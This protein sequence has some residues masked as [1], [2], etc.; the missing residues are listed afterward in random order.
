MPE[1]QTDRLS[2]LWNVHSYTH[3]YI[4][5]ADAKACV[6][7]AWAGALLGFLIS[8]DAHK[9]LLT[10]PCNWQVF[11]LR[12]AAVLAFACLAAS[13]VLAVIVVLPRVQKGTS[14]GFVFWKSIVAHGSMDHFRDAVRHL[15]ESDLESEI[16]N[17]L[18]IVASVAD[19]KYWL[20]TWSIGIG[21]LGSIA[22]AI[23]LLLR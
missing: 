9:G 22:A 3:E 10:L 19:R 18:S 4:R 12:F 15:S 8:A 1:K 7:I 20:I 13:F 21:L 2:F 14:K 11:L 6:V 23:V 17:H 5:F 16:C